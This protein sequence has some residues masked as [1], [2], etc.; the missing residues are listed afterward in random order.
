MFRTTPHRSLGARIRRAALRLQLLVLLLVS[1]ASGLLAQQLA[2]HADRL[3]DRYIA[4]GEAPD[5]A[6]SMR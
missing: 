6:G 2:P 5:E 1:A 3:A 4:I